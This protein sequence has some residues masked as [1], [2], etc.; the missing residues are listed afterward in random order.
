MTNAP[1]QHSGRDLSPDQVRDLA[2][3]PAARL[4]KPELDEVIAVREAELELM[5]GDYAIE[6]ASGYTEKL[7]ELTGLRQLRSGQDSEGKD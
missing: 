1:I 6:L 4:D 5:R 2:D 7:A 3:D